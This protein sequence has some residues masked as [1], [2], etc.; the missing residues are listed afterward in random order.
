MYFYLFFLKL[1]ILFSC[2]IFK[3]ETPLFN[4][5]TRKVIKFNFEAFLLFL[6]PNVISLM[7]EKNAHTHYCKITKIYRYIHTFIAPLEI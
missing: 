7:T 2:G 3:F 4:F 5:L 6:R 1:R